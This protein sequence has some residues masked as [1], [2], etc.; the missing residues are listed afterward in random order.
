VLWSPAVRPV[1]GIPARERVTREYH[2]DR[3]VAT[4][5]GYAGPGRAERGPQTPPELLLD[6]WDPQPIICRF[7]EKTALRGVAENPGGDVDY[8]IIR[9]GGLQ[10]RV[11]EG[12][13]IRVPRMHGEVGDAVQMSDVLALSIGGS[14]TVGTPLVESARVSAELVGHGRGRKVIVYKKKRRKSY[15]V[16]RGHRR[17]FTELRITGIQ[18]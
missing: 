7:V 11:S 18:S 17:D 5:T 14:M 8:A 13:R 9:S 10:F 3:P 16:T 1:A 2:N 12:D 6:R 15:Q 4:G